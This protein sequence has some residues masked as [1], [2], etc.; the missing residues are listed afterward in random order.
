MASHRHHPTSLMTNVRA[1]KPPV[2]TRVIRVG[3]S[4]SVSEHTI[5][6]R[7][8]LKVRHGNKSKPVKS[9]SNEYEVRAQAETE[10]KSECHR[11]VRVNRNES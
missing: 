2:D 1:V 10:L 7:T 9:E 5:L 3:V 8:S 4:Q 6:T 11:K